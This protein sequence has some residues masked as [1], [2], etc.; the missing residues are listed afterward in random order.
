MAKIKLLLTFDH[1]LFLGENTGTLESCILEPGKIILEILKKYQIQGVFFLDTYYYRRAEVEK[2]YNQKFKKLQKHLIRIL[3]ENH[4]I[5][6][7]IHPHWENAIFNGKDLT[8]DLSNQKHYRFQSLTFQKQNEIFLDS[9]NVIKEIQILSNKYYPIDSFRAGGWCIQPFDPFKKLFIE[10]KIIYDLSVI[11]EYH[12]IGDIHSYNFSNISSSA[13]YKFS[14]DPNIPD[15]HGKFIEIPITTYQWEL[16]FYKKLS[17]INAFLRDKLKV[18]N[19][20]YFGNGKMV[21]NKGTKFT[22]LNIDHFAF[23][24]LTWFTLI[25]YLIVTI[26][27]KQ[28][29]FISHTKV[30]SKHNIF[31]VRIYLFILSR[32][33]QLRSDYYSYRNF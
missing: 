4:L 29:H 31:C 20:K 13:K 2:K 19:F 28:V 8:W 22:P 30:L 10:H 3:Q 11:P 25:K 9:I 33:C 7:H 26:S 16:S 14:D 6:P 32:F 12:Y 23:E 1:E 18:N 21:Q 15:V 17:K 27:K 5:F 24:N